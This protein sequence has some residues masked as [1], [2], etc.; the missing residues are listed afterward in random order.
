MKAGRFDENYA[1][2]VNSFNWVEFYTKF[3]E[4]FKNLALY[5]SKKYRNILIDSRT[6]ITD[7]SG[8]TTML[9]PDR[10]IAVF[11][12][13]RQSLRGV[14]RVTGEALDYR[15]QSNDLRPLIIFPLPSR[16][17]ASEEDLRIKWRYGDSD[18]EILGYQVEFENLFKK[19]YD[20]ADCSLEDYF[21]DVQ[22]QHVPRYSYG[23]EI[24]ALIEPSEDRLSLAKS[25]NIFTNKILDLRAPWINPNDE[26]KNA[27]FNMPN[28]VPPPPAD[29]KGREEEICDILSNFEKGVTVTS[30]RGMA[31]IGKTALALV[32]AERLKNRFSDG[33]LI[34]NLKGTTKNPLRP[35][36][37]MAQVIHSY[38]PTDRLPENENELRGLYLSV[39]AG[40]HTLL[41]FDNA[42]DRESRSSRCY[43]L[44]IA[45]F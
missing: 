10:L 43:L 20:L 5:L 29:F 26:I 42:A 33:N 1:T 40:K 16:I 22:I 21:N 7:I 15:K 32:L 37:A 6:G 36:E 25:F 34:L 28:Q 44:K 35:A 3:P 41:L 27:P 39:L 24:A 8:I 31:G 45:P 11:T 13:N 23:E 9:M 2:N 17:E 18:Q 38:F 12:P 19:I 4:V 30:V 14:L